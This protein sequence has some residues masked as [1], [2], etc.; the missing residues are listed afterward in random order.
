M[1]FS[2][3]QEIF[4]KIIFSKQITYESL[5][6]GFFFFFLEIGGKNSLLISFLMNREER[7]F[8]MAGFKTG[9]LTAS[10]VVP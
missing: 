3:F 9:T 1:L 10:L 6:V 5:V 7:T 4:T 8:I 2:T